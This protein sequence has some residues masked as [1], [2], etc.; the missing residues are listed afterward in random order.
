MVEQAAKEGGRLVLFMGGITPGATEYEKI[1]PIIPELFEEA[2]DH[3]RQFYSEYYTPSPAKNGIQIKFS[4]PGVQ[5]F[6]PMDS[7]QI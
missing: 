6:S 7:L 4:E 5:T 2:E 1:E 3:Y